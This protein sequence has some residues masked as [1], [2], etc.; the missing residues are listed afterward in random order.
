MAVVHPA[1]HSCG[2]YEVY[3]GQADAYRALG[4]DVVTVT[5][6]DEP[7]FEPGSARWERYRGLTP[8]MEAMPRFF[9]GV[10]FARFLTPRFFARA[11]I[12]YWQGDG[13]AMR[14][15]FAEGSE[16]SQGALAQPVD[17]VHCN[18]FFCMPV[19]Q[20]IARGAP[21]VLDTIDVQARQ[22]DI[23][24]DAARFVLPPRATFDAMLR[25]ELAA[26]RPAAGLLHLNA[27][28]MDFFQAR[29]PDNAHHLL[30]PAVRAMTGA[31]EGKDIL[32]VASNNTREC[33][34]PDLVFAR[35]A[36]SRRQSSCRHRGQC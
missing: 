9:A 10:S 5:C 31:A 28:E 14:E 2:A 6:S 24:N 32:I 17:L 1:W 26:M 20:R 36:A 35:R 7:G 12:P 27:E 25:Q 11:V 16:I 18:H 3:V 33:R 30:Y 15:G 22:F 34:K 4:A 19:A 29:L 21:I 23:I 13:A 8:E